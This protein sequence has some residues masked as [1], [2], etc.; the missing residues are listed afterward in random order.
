L[1]ADAEDDAA[2]FDAHARGTGSFSAHRESRSNVLELAI[3]Q[4]HEQAR[5]LGD[6]VD[7]D[8][9]DTPLEQNLFNGSFASP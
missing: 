2:T 7:A 1:A 8:G 3:G 4:D 9:Q 5:T 6:V